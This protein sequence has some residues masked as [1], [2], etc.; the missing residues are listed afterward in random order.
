MN[1]NA[2][3]A[4]A[5]V[6]LLLMLS[7]SSAAVVGTATIR[8]PA[9]IVT[10]NTGSL[11]TITLVITNG[12]G[13]VTVTGPQTVANSTIQSATTAAA[14]ASNY[15]GHML[16]DYNF[17]YNI[18]DAGDNVSGPSAGAA[19]TI[20][21]VS[22]FTNIPLRKD[23]TMTGTISGNGSIGQ[24]GGVYDKASAAKASG[25]DLI[26]VP[27]VAQ[28]DPEDELYLLVQT[29]FGIPLV[30]VANISQAAYFAFNSDING[31]SNETE[32]NFYTDMHAPELPQAG[33]NCS[34]L[35]NYTIFGYLL[36][37]TFNLTHNE[38][39]MLD[40]NPKFYGIGSQMGRV[41]N[42]SMAIAEH[43]YLYVGADYSFLDYVNAFYFNGYSTNRSAALSTLYA[44]QYFCNSL[45][46][47]Q[48]TTSN[49]NYVINAELRQEWGDYSINSTISSYNSSQ[50]DSDEIL[51]E[52]YV[53]AQANGW[54]SAANIVFN[55]SGRNQGGT[56]VVPSSALGPIAASRLARASQYGP[57]MYYTT[58]EQAYSQS[59]Y[60]VRN[61]RCRLCVR[62]LKRRIKIH[63]IY[64]A[65]EQP[66]NGDSPELNIRGL[67]HGVR[68]GGAVLRKRD[69]PHQQ[70]DRGKGLC[71]NGL[72]IGAA[73]TADKQ[74]HKGD[75]RQPSKH[76]WAAEHRSLNFRD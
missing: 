68:Q 25:A 49:Y 8:A 56:P 5:I 48:L 35:C 38:I 10:N 2:M 39:N 63:A 53:G 15:T 11:T 74:R 45:K 21:A 67:G 40:A 19:M 27:K 32:Y 22:A 43:G 4:L 61:S 76:K 20:L 31:L 29:N 62:A 46:P 72:C 51:D 70:L 24:I 1:K 33:I 55:A 7:Y 34:A 12:N 30:Q 42:Q 73:C 47:P 66:D 75:K 65:A 52:L 23:F 50:I 17:S 14:Y 44:I 3:F 18:S 26:L 41:L 59:N 60:P 54:C 71:G 9:V 58:A 64:R 36:N 6:G 28:T 57:S 37:S 16:S 69:R 13:A